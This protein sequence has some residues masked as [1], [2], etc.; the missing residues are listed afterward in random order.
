MDGS[1]EQLLTVDRAALTRDHLFDH[2][3]AVNTAI[4]QFSAELERDLAALTQP[5]DAD[6]PKNYRCEE[7][8]CALRWS[9]GFTQARIVQAHKLVHEL[10][11]TL[12]A[13]SAGVIAPEQARAVAEACY[14]LEPTLC[15][16][17]QDRVLQRAAAQTVTELKR[18]L[19]RAV[20]TLDPRGYAERHQ[21]AQ[22]QRD[23]YLSLLP[24]GMAGLWSTHTTADAH[25]I[26]AALQRLADRGRGDS[27]LVGQRR[28]DALRD[29]ILGV[30]QSVPPGKPVNHR[31][32]SPLARY[33]YQ[34]CPALRA[35]IVQRDQTCRMP[36]CNRR[37]INCEL[38]HLTRYNGSNTV[39]ANLIALCPRH[40]HLRHDGGWQIHR[41]ADG[42]T[43][44]TS[45]T[46]RTYL[47]PPPE[48]DDEPP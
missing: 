37:A 14:G 46:G 4:S 44:W 38:H 25:A 7:I 39:E 11:E 33:Q 28:A 16:K 20:K 36:G 12:T 23:V 40:H 26:M 2:L 35:A 29:L 24:D 13:L 42:T 30:G 10:P 22:R 41:R 21:I 18:S 19:T 3:V 31:P 48:P 32:V 45:P 8:A 9:A 17:V 43:E 47:K 5:V 34:P 15:T 1:L 27:R 6:D